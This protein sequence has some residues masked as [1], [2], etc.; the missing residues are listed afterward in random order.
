MGDEVVAR[1]LKNNVFILNV[2]E[3]KIIRLFSADEPERFFT[4]NYFLCSIMSH[5]VTELSKN[6]KHSLSFYNRSSG[7]FIA[8]G[9]PGGHRK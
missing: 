2:I 1:T 3:G 8:L 5:I 6:D 7:S 4:E 9:G